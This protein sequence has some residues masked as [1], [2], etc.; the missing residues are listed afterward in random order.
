MAALSRSLE[1]G[2]LKSKSVSAR[3]YRVA[4]RSQSGL[5]FSSQQSFTIECA[6][7][8]RSYLDLNCMYLQFE[9]E[10]ADAAAADGRLDF[11]AYSIFNRIT[12]ASSAGSILEDTNYLNIY[13]AMLLQS[14][15]SEEYQKGYGATIGHAG[16]PGTPR[17][18]AIPASGSKITFCLPM[19]TG[20]S[21]ANRQ[22][23]L[24]GLRV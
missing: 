8:Q 1:Y 6:Q 21:T 5:S 12:V 4:F 23:P 15:C 3:N 24:D 7:L 18:I 13:N 10:H 9:I 2:R 11:S 16:E 19:L 14:Q 17:G 20:L 22:L